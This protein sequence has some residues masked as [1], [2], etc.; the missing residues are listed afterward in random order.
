[1]TT[2][3]DKKYP[4]ATSGNDLMTSAE[5]AALF[6]VSVSTVRRWTRNKQ[7]KGYQLGGRGDWRYVR[8]DVISFLMGNE[9]D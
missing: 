1:M 8:K 7:L 4:N 2:N 5:V 9:I 3:D 6:K